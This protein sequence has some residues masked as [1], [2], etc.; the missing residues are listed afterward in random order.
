MPSHVSR[1]LLAVVLG[2]GLGFGLLANACVLP[3]P[4]H[5]HNLA[6][7][8]NVW[9]AARFEERP[10]CSP[11]EAEGYGCVADEPTAEACPEYT[12]SEAS[13]TGDT[14]S[15]TGDTG[16]TETGDTG[17]TDTGDAGSTETG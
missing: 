1:K 16:S 14:G 11:C 7:D 12:P 9:C 3:N 5:C 4:D 13:E 8:P 15:E 6:I 17:S 10:Y 2:V